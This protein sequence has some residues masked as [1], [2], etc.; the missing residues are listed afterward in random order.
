MRCLGFILE[1]RDKNDQPVPKTFF[2]LL[3][4]H[5]DNAKNEALADLLNHLRIRNED[6]L[7]DFRLIFTGGTF[8]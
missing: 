3:A 1:R 7:K 2:A 4:S 6:L 5:D 8:D